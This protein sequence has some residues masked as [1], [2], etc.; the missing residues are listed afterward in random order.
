MMPP[1]RMRIA[2]ENGLR[3]FLRYRYTN[4][5]IRKMD[6][7]DKRRRPRSGWRSQPRRRPFRVWLKSLQARKAFSI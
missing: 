2:L 5:P 7:D 4:Q 3:D 1:R 6:A